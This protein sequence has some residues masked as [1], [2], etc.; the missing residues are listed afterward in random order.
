VSLAKA[1]QTLRADRERGYRD[2]RPLLWSTSFVWL[3]FLAFHLREDPS[4][5]VKDGPTLAAW[6]AIGA[7]LNLLPLEGWQSAPFA[8]DDPI[9][10]AVA[11]IFR[12]I[13]TGL[14]VFLGAFDPRELRGET[15]LV[16]SIWNRS[17]LS[18]SWC[19]ASFTV[20]I[21]T[22]NPGESSF[23]LPLAFLGLAMASVLNYSLVA[24]S[25]AF[26]R[27]YQVRDVFP[28]L[29]IGVFQDFVLAFVTWG[30]LAAMLIALYDRVGT[31]ALLAFLAPVLFARQALERSQEYVDTSRAYHSREAA[32]VELSR[33]IDQERAD[34][35]W[36]V[37]AD[38][39]DDVLQPLFKVTLLSQ[40][41]RAELRNGRLL[42]MEDDLPELIAAA[43]VAS[44]TVRSLMGDLRRPG[45]G[46][47]GLPQALGRLIQMLREQSEIKFHPSIASIDIDPGQQLVLYQ[48]AKEGLTNAVQHAH[49]RTI[50]VEL[51]QEGD[52]VI[53]KI[54]DDGRGFD[55][56][57]EK[58][59]HYGIAIM[60]ERAATARGTFFVDSIPGVGS[61]LTVAVPLQEKARPEDV[62]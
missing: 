24:L 21:L 60:R 51:R 28:K 15:P 31:L 23:A 26:E 54:R 1:R 11:L 22:R 49:A 34:E 50:W 43:E 52:A 17:Q 8:A 7:L 2:I 41:L 32:L 33:Q 30:V 56:F 57:V 45:L 13:E 5:L 46:R 47:G 35:R 37:A 36:L 58:Q 39:H 4:A 44:D 48:V 29:K 20:H 6:I 25:I 16:K 62:A 12:P 27:R 55:P 3:V 42:E 53:L 14:V 40:V 19:I 38:L 61:T 10:L 9:V 18:F 59:G